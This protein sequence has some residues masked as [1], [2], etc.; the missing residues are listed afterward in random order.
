MGEQEEGKRTRRTEDEQSG[1]PGK[2]QVSPWEWLVAAAGLVLVVSTI[3]FMLYNALA[4]GAAP[5]SIEVQVLSIVRVGDGFL[6]TFTATNQGDMTAAD[7]TVEGEL[8]DDAGSKETSTATISYVPAGSSREGGLYFAQDPRQFR[9]E[10]R[11]KGFE[12]P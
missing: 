8:R 4:E 3:G 10:V 12:R 5:P 6:V 2:A 7:V 1:E 11:A 9:M